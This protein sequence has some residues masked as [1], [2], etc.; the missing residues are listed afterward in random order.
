MEEKIGQATQS[1]DPVLQRVAVDRDM[2]VVTLAREHEARRLAWMEYPLGSHRQRDRMQ[3]LGLVVGGRWGPE[4]RLV[5]M[6]PSHCGERR[7]AFAGQQQQAQIPECG[8]EQGHE[9]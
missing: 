4:P 1:N 3:E 5:N 2:S 7:L 9:G 8:A 6:F